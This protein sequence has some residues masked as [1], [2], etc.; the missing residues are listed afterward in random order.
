MG[1]YN[2]VSESGFANALICCPRI[3][4]RSESHRRLT[5]TY[6][7]WHNLFCC[8]YRKTMSNSENPPALDSTSQAKEGEKDRMDRMEDTIAKLGNIVKNFIEQ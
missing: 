6:V 2:L 8:G 7:R 4:L 3:G 5:T 1:C